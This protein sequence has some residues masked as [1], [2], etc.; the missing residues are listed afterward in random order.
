[1]FV[2]MYLSLYKKYLSRYLL[3]PRI[4]II[5]YLVVYHVTQ[6]A[7][8]DLCILRVVHIIQKHIVWYILQ[9]P[10]FSPS[11]MPTAMKRPLLVVLSLL[12]ALSSVAAFNGP[13]APKFITELRGGGEAPNTKDY[14]DQAKALFGDIR[15]PASLFAGASA[16][17]AFAM[18]LT[19][20]DGLRLG[21]VKRFYALI[22]MGALSSQLL[23]IVVATLTVGTITCES[24]KLEAAK[25]VGEFITKNFDVEWTVVRASFLGGILGFVVAAGMRARVTIGCSVFAKATLGIV[26]SATLLAVAFLEE[27][28]REKS[29]GSI[30]GLGFKCLKLLAGKARSEP[31]FAAG[32]VS[33]ALTW[34]YLL[35]QGSHI[36]HHLCKIN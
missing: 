8:Q 22:M 34:G 17:A 27:A 4:I 25:S 11:T 32:L 35:S 12:L 9:S 21:L 1:M 31:L 26:I 36:Y 28:E 13:R 29:G 3:R 5:L 18:P 30:F 15:F 16:G 2:Q 33:S 23:A 24:R 20:N 10:F 6:N 19:A 14:S 7:C